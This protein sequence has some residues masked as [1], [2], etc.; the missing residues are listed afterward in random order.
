ML[1]GTPNVDQTEKLVRLW[2]A[3]IE[4]KSYWVVTNR[5]DIPDKQ[6]ALV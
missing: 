5:F 4:A 3:N 6:V 2:V 1:L